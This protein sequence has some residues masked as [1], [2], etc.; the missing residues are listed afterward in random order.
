MKK[1][2][3][4]IVLFASI[5]SKGY[6]QT[7][8]S[9][10]DIAFTGYW[11]FDGTD[12]KNDFSFV[13]LKSGGI[14]S[15]TTIYF[16]DQGYNGSN[17]SATSEGTIT[18][19]ATS[20]LS[21]FDE[22]TVDIA[23]AGT[24]GS[25]S[26]GSVSVSGFFILSAA[27]D[28]IFAFNSATF[29]TAN[30]LTG[31][32]VNVENG[33]FVTTPTNWDLITSS[34]IGGCGSC[35][36]I[37]STRSTKPSVL[38][39]GTNAIFLA[40]GSSTPYTEFDNGKYNCTGASGASL[41]AVRSS[42]NDP[43]NWTLTNS[44]TV[45]LPSGCSF[46]VSTATTWNG[47]TWSGG[48]P[49]ASVDAIIASSTTPGTFTCKGL[50]INS[51]FALTMSGGTTATLNGNLVNNGNGFSGSGNFV[52][53]ATGSIT[54]N[55]VSTEGVVT[56]SSGATLTTNGNLTLAASSNS[57]YGQIGNSAG[58]IS[59]NV[60]V[61][62]FLS[63]K[64]AFRFMGH[65]FT[66]SQA[67][68][69]ITDDID[70]TGSGGSSN[71]FTTTASNNPSAFW[72]DVTAADNST[73]GNNPGWVAFTTASSSQWDQY[74]LIRVLGR[75]A[76]GQGLTGGSYTPS[77][78]TI[79][80]TGAVNQGTQVV[81]L[82]K[83]SSSN[84]VSCGNPFPSGV[85]M[86]AV[87]KGAN[88]GANYYVWDAT[89]GAA[90]AYVTNAFTLSYVLPPFSALFTTATANSSNT[91][92]F[93]EA[94][95]AATGTGLFKTTANDNW[96]ELIIEDSTIHWDRLLINLDDN[97]MEV[98]DDLDATKL[99]NPGLDFFTLSKDDKRLAI[100]VRPYDDGKSILLGLTAY[101]RYN[102]YVIKTGM[103]DV[104]AGT[105]LY[106]H[107]KYLNKKE[108]LT[109][110]FEYWFDVTSDSLSQGN[111]RFEINMVGKPT[112]SIT[113]INNGTPTLH[114]IPNPALDEVRIAFTT[115][116]AKAKL[117]ITN[118]AGQVIYTSQIN[119]G[120]NSKDVPLQNIPAGMYIVELKGD[121]I[122]LTEK[123]IKR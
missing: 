87:T 81:T 114:L 27:G 35:L 45:T 23:D 115:L 74:E 83:G 116:E 50:T 15:G 1:I 38:T 34:G 24:S 107:D 41:T 14:T 6:S 92:T 90:G 18:W 55:A 5:S 46:A 80:M 86:N 76:K 58:T 26:S 82:T 65:P 71:G 97:A 4:L 7:S 30:L 66:T 69:T 84:F 2:L 72:F 22:V 8:L 95:K 73:A 99:Y 94:D 102:S 70:V 104:P 33:S 89:S 122:S 110:G 106:L 49:T 57:S 54:G 62:R 31:I 9:L 123:L 19:T 120:E 17:F 28:Q 121:N 47:S 101:N 77:A 25:A 56:V 60:T 112:T 109:A 40:S 48:T 111:E 108:E 59:G 117:Q 75:G 100:D 3:I 53:N 20:S 85:Q 68:S 13:I 105:K 79:D 21:Q 37:T 39:S 43:S 16:T 44:N 91:L 98:Q 96:V 113:T 51:G 103:F 119:S 63:G 93:E 61:E 32:H 42:I 29:T 67:L 88:I 118:V 10:G 78:A 52:F 64:R 12:N 11:S 36:T